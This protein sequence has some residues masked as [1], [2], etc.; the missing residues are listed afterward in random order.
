MWKCKMRN[1]ASSA[2]KYFVVPAGLWMLDWENTCLIHSV[3]ASECEKWA[4]THHAW[5]WVRH[6][7][8]VNPPLVIGALSVGERSIKSFPDISHAINAHSKALEYVAV[9]QRGD[10]S[11]EQ[12]VKERLWASMAKN[13]DITKLQL[14]N[15]YKRKANLT[16]TKQTNKQKHVFHL[17]VLKMA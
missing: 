2:Q 17:I 16:S 3:V 1:C 11:D 15:K 14:E 10:V 6:P 7:A 4:N 13:S 5:P 8:L 12:I 9:E